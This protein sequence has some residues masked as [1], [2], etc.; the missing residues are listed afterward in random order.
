MKRP[1]KRCEK[2]KNKLWNVVAHISPIKQQNEVI[3]RMRCDFSKNNAS[4]TW[5]QKLFLESIVYPMHFVNYWSQTMKNAIKYIPCFHLLTVF[6]KSICVY[7]FANNF[8]EIFMWVRV[9]ILTIRAGEWFLSIDHFCALLM[10]IN[11]REWRTC[12]R[13]WNHDK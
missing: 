12:L 3:S 7:L 10:R 6:W 11:N 9:C 5:E 13:Q 2:V 1:V 4:L 8:Y